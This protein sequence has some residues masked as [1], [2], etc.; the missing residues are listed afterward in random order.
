MDVRPDRPERRIPAGHVAD[1]ELVAV[2]AGGDERVH[3]RVHELGREVAGGGE[4]AGE[5]PVAVGRQHGSDE[6]ADPD[7][8]P[9]RAQERVLDLELE[10][11][12]DDD[13]DVRARGVDERKVGLERVGVA[14]TVVDHD[15][16]RHRAGGRGLGDVERR[17]AD[18]DP[19]LAERALQRAHH[20][21]FDAGAGVEPGD[22]PPQGAR[23]DRLLGERRVVLVAHVAP[24]QQRHEPI[25]HDELSVVALLEVLDGR[26]A[27]HRARDANLDAR[28]CRQPSQ[29]RV[30]R[31]ERA[32]EAVER[33][34]EHA[35]AHAARA[36]VGQGALDAV[37]DLVVCDHVGLE[38]DAPPAARDRP[39]QPVARPGVVE[40][41]PR[42]ERRRGAARRWSP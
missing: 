3:A 29:N 27:G 7:A 30:G 33:I 24:S 39:E 34:D 17:A 16:R 19:G 1:R 11:E 10:R 42:R 18:V 32:V 26:D 28:G 31:A 4:G 5:R 35:H 22:A 2:G 14:Q 40:S 15:A 13:V 36:R 12:A 8:A 38:M 20:G 37:R 41:R 9:Q 6:R 23:G 25:D 21:P